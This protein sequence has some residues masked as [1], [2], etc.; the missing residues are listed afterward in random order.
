MR[1]V[2]Q[3]LTCRLTA[4]AV[5]AHDS[6]SQLGE[7]QFRGYHRLEPAAHEPVSDGRRT[8]QA[9]HSSNLF[10][11]MTLPEEDIRAARRLDRIEDQLAL[12]LIAGLALVIV[13]VCCVLATL[14]TEDPFA[15]PP[16]RPVGWPLTPM[17]V[18]PEG[19]LF[20]FRIPAVLHRGREKRSFDVL[21]CHNE[22]VCH[23][24]VDE[25]QPDQSASICLRTIVEDKLLAFVRTEQDEEQSCQICTSD[26]T[27][28]AKIISR[29]GRYI[30]QKDKEIL[31]ICYGDFSNHHVRMLDSN[32]RKVAMTQPDA[33]GFTGSVMSGEDVGLVLCTLL[34]IEK[35]EDALKVIDEIYLEGDELKMSTDTVMD[36]RDDPFFSS[37]K[38]SDT[39]H[40]QP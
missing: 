34:A 36:K 28:F 16:H 14:N 29:H 20:L 5:Q 19:K 26:G 22:A 12:A 33:E 11:F 21:D 40:P 38:A 25:L 35:L 10:E 18:V 15:G 1:I 7:K 32:N 30:V 37:E 6:T 4:E 39:D 2:W 23:V 24:S 17:L 27:V 8:V 9:W 31:L 3:L 13:T